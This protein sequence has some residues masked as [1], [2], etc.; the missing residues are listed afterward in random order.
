[1]YDDDHHHHYMYVHYMRVK[2]FYTHVDHFRRSPV[3]AALSRDFVLYH[4]TSHAAAGLPCK[5]AVTSE[6]ACPVL[7]LHAAIRL[8]IHCTAQ[9][10]T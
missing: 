2:L 5:T 9:P 10:Y 8:A 4:K 6:N 1:M 3:F 7:T